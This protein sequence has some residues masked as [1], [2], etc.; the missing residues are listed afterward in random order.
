MNEP[1]VTAIDFDSSERT[2]WQCLPFPSTL[3]SNEQLGFELAV[4]VR[5]ECVDHPLERR[6]EAGP[7]A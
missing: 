5:R 6:E 7:V 2:A 3:Q 4:M 1:V